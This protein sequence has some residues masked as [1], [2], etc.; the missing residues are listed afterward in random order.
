MPVI[1]EVA[2][3]KTRARVYTKE[4]I[5][6]LGG[7]PGPQGPPGRQGETGEQGQVGPPGPQGEPGARGDLGPYVFEVVDGYLHLVYADGET[8]PNYAINASGELILTI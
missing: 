3:S 6:K 4:E 5:E 7:V 2:G 8:A 1:V